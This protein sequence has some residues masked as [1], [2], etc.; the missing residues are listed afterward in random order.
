MG[1][2][3]DAYRNLKPVYDRYK[4]LKDKEKFLCGFESEI[5]LFEAVARNIKKVG[6]TKL[7]SNEKIITELVGLSACKTVLQVELRRI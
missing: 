2:Q 3:I 1:K 7:P 4:V 6:L 5:I